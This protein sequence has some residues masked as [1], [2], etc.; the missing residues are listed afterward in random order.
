MSDF[1]CEAETEKID[2]S[3]EMNQI[4]L[5]PV[6]KVISTLTTEWAPSVN[7]ISFKLETDE[8]LIIKKSKKYFDQGKIQVK[9]SKNDFR[10]QSRYW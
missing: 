4:R 1:T 3:R 7:T 2:S 5:F 8:S 6:K 9:S 10:S